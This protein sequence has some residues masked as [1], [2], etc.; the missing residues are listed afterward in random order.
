VAKRNAETDKLVALLQQYLPRI[1]GQVSIVDDI[2]SSLKYGDAVSNPSYKQLL[3]SLQ[4]QAMGA[5]P[6]IAGLVRTITI[7]NGTEFA[8][9]QNVKFMCK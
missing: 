6:P 7:D 4:Q 9:L 3:V 5:I 2:V 8:N 1:K